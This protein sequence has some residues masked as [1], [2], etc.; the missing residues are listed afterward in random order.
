MIRSNFR[1]RFGL[2]DA[3]DFKNYSL[4]GTNGISHT[5][6]KRIREG[7]MGGQFWAVYGDCSTQG[8]DAVRFFLEQLDS[9]KRIFKRYPETFKFAQTANGIKLIIFFLFL[10]TWRING[11]YF[12]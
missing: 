4:N 8:K 3:T 6:I 2:F 7:R 9:L 12:I 5:D 11:F 1:N 10:N